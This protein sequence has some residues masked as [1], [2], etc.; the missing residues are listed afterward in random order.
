M[1]TKHFPTLM[2]IQVNFDPNVDTDCVTEILPSYATQDLSAYYTHKCMYTHHF[3]T[4]RSS[5]HFNRNKKRIYKSL[6]FT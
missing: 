3:D 1:L 2:T 5:F 4:Q 6:S